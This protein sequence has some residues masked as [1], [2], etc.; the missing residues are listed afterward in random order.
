MSQVQPLDAPVGRA[1]MASLRARFMVALVAATVL[2]LTVAGLVTWSLERGRLDDQI[3]TDL[4]R[5]RS[6]VAQIAQ[7]GADPYS[8][9]RLTDVDM[10]L[11]SIMQS[12]LPGPNQGEIGLIDGAVALIAP[13]GTRVRPENLRGLVEDVL[14]SPDARIHTSDSADGTYRYAVMPVSVPGDARTGALVTVFDLRAERRALDSNFR[15]YALAGLGTGLL[16][17]LLTWLLLGRLLQPLGWVR[18]TAQQISDEDLSRRIPVRGHDDLADLTRTINAML[19]R[20]EATFAAERQLHDDVGHELR[21]PLTVMR[22]NLELVDPTD[23]V[24]VTNARQ[25]ALS[26]IDRMAGLVEDLITLAKSERPDF[27]DPHPIDVAPLTEQVL[28]K[29]RGMGDRRWTLDGVADLVAELDEARV[30][31]ALLELTRNAVKFSDPGSEI[32]IG[33]GTREGRLQLWVRDHGRGIPPD[34]LAEV[35]ER[36]TRLQSDVAGSGLGLSI[37]GSIARAHGGSLTIDSTPGRGSTFTLDLPLAE[38]DEDLAEPFDP[39]P[40][41]EELTL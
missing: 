29:A 6:E 39:A 35:T 23:P 16:V 22:G 11:R 8:G 20:I 27:V 21:T 12:A 7:R 25:L 10:A 36:F 18:R 37:V 40:M 19:D 38:D 17:C 5:R 9:Q 31:Q 14:A 4:T 2:T 26:E 32:A 30:S 33:S 24:D 28:E 15:S 13:D 1:R 3:D 34:R 41:H